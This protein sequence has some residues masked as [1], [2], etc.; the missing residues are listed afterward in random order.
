M[1]EPEILFSPLPEPEP[2]QHGLRDARHAESVLFCL[3]PSV[4]A[5]DGDV[6]EPAPE[7]GSGLV[8]IR[9]LL[10]AREAIPAASPH[11][12]LPADP[13]TP[14]HPPSPSAARPPIPTPWLLGAVLTLL[15]AFGL[16][17]WKVQAFL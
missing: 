6:D 2:E 14:L 16:L 11:R 9:G 4:E 15:A 10:D 8:D 13:P 7:E 3:N 17:A 1:P 5:T 12:L